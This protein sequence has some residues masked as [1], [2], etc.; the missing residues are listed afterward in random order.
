[1]FFVVSVSSIFR[2]PL[3]LVA[4]LN[5]RHAFKSR[6]FYGRVDAAQFYYHLFFSGVLGRNSSRFDGVCR[7]VAAN[8]RSRPRKFRRRCF[9]GNLRRSLARRGKPHFNRYGWLVRQTRTDYGTILILDFRFWI[10]DWKKGI[11]FCLNRL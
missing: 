3:A 4:W 6:L 8:R 5:L 11:I 9:C 10:L 7:N 1:M 2:A